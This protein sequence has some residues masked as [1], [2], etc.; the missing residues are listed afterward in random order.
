MFLL[1]ERFDTWWATPLHIPC[2]IIVKCKKYKKY[3]ELQSFSEG[4]GRIGPI[5][6]GGMPGVCTKAVQRRRWW[7]TKM[8]TTRRP[9]RRL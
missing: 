4:A 7:G 3:S 2:Q 8:Q 5:R 6:G 9:N 1:L